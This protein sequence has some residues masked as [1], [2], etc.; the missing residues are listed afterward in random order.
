MGIKLSKVAVRTSLAALATGGLLAS[1]LVASPSEAAT[2]A[3]ARTV[4]SST[5]QTQTVA[6]KKTARRAAAKKA[7]K[8]KA[9][10]RRAAKRR[11]KRRARRK[12]AQ[13]KAAQQAA[14][15]KSPSTPPAPASPPAQTT[16]RSRQPQIT[17]YSVAPNYRKVAAPNTFFPVE[18]RRLVKDQKSFSSRHLGTDLVAP[19]NS[20]VVAAHAGTVTVETSTRWA[21]P[22]VV[23]VSSRAGGLVTSAA[24]LSSVTVQPG[25]V[26]AAGQQIGTVG[27]RAT[28]EGCRTYFSVNDAGKWVNP[29]SWLNTYVGNPAPVGALFDD[30][31]FVL[32]SFNVLGASHTK[33]GG[34]YAVAAQR[35]PR[36][37]QLIEDWGVDVAGLQEF[38]DGQKADF[39][40]LAGGAFGVYNF[41]GPRGKEDTDN[42]IVWRKSVFDFVHGETYDIPYFHGN[43]RHMP[44]VLLRNRLTGRLAYF[45]N[46]HNPANVRGPAQKWRDQAIEIERQKIIELRKTGRAVF[47]T[48]DF[49]DRQNAFCP[50]TAS[51]LSISPNS[52]PSMTCAYPKQGSIDWIYAAGPTRFS[53]FMRDKTPQQTAISD[54]PIVVAQAHLQ[55]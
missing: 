27:A 11:A 44:L 46:T 3:Q 42:A 10:K 34:K 55:Y 39:L 13:Q 1:G 9:A 20:P 51:M 14:Q 30:P 45:M 48:G 29:S 41:T 47:L 37:Y 12:A 38:Q 35:T 19:C 5:V 22:Y 8:R 54:H 2:G 40:N 16:R 21:N 6:Q 31:G 52:V 17:N 26:V 36:A 15:Q 50:L 4:A 28:K 33:H 7:A 23:R 53:W 43:T 25:Q 32:A 18:G 49:N 24:Y